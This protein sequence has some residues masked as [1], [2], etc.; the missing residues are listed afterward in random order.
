MVVG[1]W[2]VKGDLK[3]AKDRVTCE[4]SVQVASKLGQAMEQLLQMVQPVIVASE[5]ERVREESE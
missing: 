2:T 1:L 4:A 5:R 3:R